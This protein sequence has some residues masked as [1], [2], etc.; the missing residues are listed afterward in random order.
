M[1]R[2]L[3]ASHNEGKIKEF[4]EIL[5]PLGVEVLSAA[6]LKV[7]DVEETGKTFAEN[8]ELK[9]EAMAAETGFICVSDDS[10]LC[11][12]ALGGKPGVYSA[13]YAPNRDFEKGMDI[14]L[15]ELNAT[16]SKDRSA[17]FM[18]VLALAVP[19]GKLKTFEGR[20][21]GTIA[22]EKKGENGFGYDKIFIPEGFDKTFGEMEKDEKNTM[23][24][25]G[26]ALE[27]FV[28]YM[29]IKNG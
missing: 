15:D 5:Q 16:G 7:S 10:G 17:Y 13:R 3:V 24:H 14:L 22:L 26:R 18:C 29:K 28:E 20:V 8:A 2:I 11:V 21:N 27:K 23:S 6:D 1:K 4:K 9:A 25:R 19:D 12:N